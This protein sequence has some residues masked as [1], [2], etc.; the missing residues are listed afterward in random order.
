MFASALCCH[1]AR[2]SVRLARALWQ[3]RRSLAVPEGE[4]PGGISRAHVSTSAWLPGR[5]G[6]LKSPPLVA[7]LTAGRRSA[8]DELRSLLRGFGLPGGIPGQR[9]SGRAPAVKPLR[10]A[11]GRATGH[12]ARTMRSGWLARAAFV[13]GSAG[14]A[15]LWYRH[16]GGCA[17]GVPPAH[18]WHPTISCFSYFVRL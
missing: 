9:S 14:S 8:A 13:F 7:G 11:R 10:L 18:S 4:L 3:S 12:S 15:G 2:C 16:P 6:L 17:W 1:Q 5:C